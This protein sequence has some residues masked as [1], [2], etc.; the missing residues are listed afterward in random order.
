M[1]KARPLIY[2]IGCPKCKALERLFKSKGIEYDV[3]TDV[4]IM[5]DKGFEYLPQMEYKGE[6][7]DVEAAEEWAEN[8]KGE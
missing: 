3:C 7:Y 4:Q 6:I 8:Y 1:E 5:V 2:T